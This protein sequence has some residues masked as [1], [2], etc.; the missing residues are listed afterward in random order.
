MAADNEAPRVTAAYLPL[1][2]VGV[3]HDKV[4]APQLANP[5]LAS[6]EA[7]SLEDM[8]TEPPIRQH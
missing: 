1:D 4:A 6:I 8:V 7:A 2:G 3:D 5:A